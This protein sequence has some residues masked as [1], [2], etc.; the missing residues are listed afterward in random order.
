MDAVWAVSS[1]PL[2]FSQNELGRALLFACFF[3]RLDE[4]LVDSPVW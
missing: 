2:K 1:S 3:H 4:E